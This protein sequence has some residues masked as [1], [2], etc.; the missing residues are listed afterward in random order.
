MSDT[1]PPFSPYEWYSLTPER[2]AAAV[3]E[4]LLVREA[5][6]AAER[7]KAEAVH[8]AAFVGSS[9]LRR[10]ILEL[11]RPMFDQLSSR[12]ECSFCYDSDDG[13]DDWPCETYVLARDF[14]EATA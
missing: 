6:R 5:E 7:D 11:H 1:E 8:C 2:Q 13:A 3:A 10:A 9:G 4:L 14:P 12:A